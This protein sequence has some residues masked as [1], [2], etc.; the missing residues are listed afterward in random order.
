MTLT[1]QPVS[2]SLNY[3]LS[4]VIWQKA[5]DTPLTLTYDFLQQAPT[6]LL[7]VV[8]GDP[9]ENIGWA[10][11]TTAEQTAAIQ[12]LA[13]ISSVA[14]ITFVASTNEATSDIL[15][16]TNNQVT[17]GAYTTYGA[18][19]YLPNGQY[20]VQ[21][22]HIEISNSGFSLT[23]NNFMGAFLHEMANATGLQDFVVET[24]VPDSINSLDYAVESY[25]GSI[26]S[27]YSKGMYNGNQ[28]TT[29]QIL[30]ILAW[31]YL[32]GA[33]QNGFTPSVQ[34]VTESH[35]GNNHTYTFSAETAL[36]TVWIGANVSGVNCFDF[37][38]CGEVVIDLTPGT[39]SSTDTN[40]P[41][42]TAITG[43]GQS[44]DVSNTPWQNVGIAFGTTIQIAIAGFDNA[45][46]YGDATPGHN[47]LL[48]GGLGENFPGLPTGDI[49]VA[50]GGTDIA[51][52]KGGPSNTA[53]FHDAY[54]DYKI[55]T[56]VDGGL[57]VTDQAAK[58]S[59]GTMILVGGFT[60]L[61]FADQTIAVQQA[62]NASVPVVD[63]AANLSSELDLVQAF[64]TDGYFNQI[65]LTD[66]GT[67]TLSLT[68]AQLVPDA[69]VLAAITTPYAL[70][71]AAGSG[72]TTIVGP[73]KGIA[74]T[75]VLPDPV[76]DY[77]ITEKADG[78]LA[79]TNGAVTDLVS[80][81]TA[82]QFS[83][84]TIFVAS[85]TPASAGGVSSA[86][87]VSLYSAVLA[88]EPDAA[89]LAFYE[90]SITAN[91]SL[92]LVQYSEFF[93]SSSEYTANSAHAYA[94]SATGDGQFINDIY[95]NLLHR[96]PESGAVPYY[97][98]VVTDYTKGLTPGTT[99]YANAQLVGHAQVLVY[100]SASSEFIGDVQ[101][102]AQT[103][104]SAQHWLYLV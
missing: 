39:L 75:V 40:S 30:D 3:L 43:S 38:Q 63:T 48:I 17:S 2:T 66:S 50:G 67:P 61:E 35:I 27:V 25:G 56:G 77:Q 58:P 47:D 84:H 101:I 15:L 41:G 86:Q 69:G 91:P 45:T 8:S 83:D 76:A 32:Y 24:S 80:N 19:A 44:V 49:F 23:P 65:A 93:L 42:M 97:Q 59:D 9:A 29:P 92:S 103:P 20:L 28:P 60:S 78:A 34:G 62:V 68:A 94:Q 79:L 37:S 6:T 12:A 46:L 85:T 87:I 64:I 70:S 36:A 1:A 26:G 95:Q 57:I 33:N 54:A 81:V 51:L 74:T 18:G 100:I 22:L 104:A 5:S 21:Q 90:N 7:E 98:A 53:V 52:A 72:N 14:N 82:L 89:G 88:R 16:G 10:P 11:M 55:T 99:A 31:Q 96:A 71:V 13:T 4:S 102:T 73:G